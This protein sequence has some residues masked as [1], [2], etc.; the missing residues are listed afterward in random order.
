M[1]AFLDKNNSTVN[2]HLDT[3]LYTHL[4]VAN[5]TTPT[6][7]ITILYGGCIVIYDN[8]TNTLYSK[9]DAP[10]YTHLGLLHSTTTTVSNPIMYTVCIAI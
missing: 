4:G 9:L 6:V 8:Q 2:I 5:Y 10:M 1:T 7:S 3:A